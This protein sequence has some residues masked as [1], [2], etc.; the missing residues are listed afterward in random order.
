MAW[1][2]CTSAA[3]IIRAG[4]YANS[5]ITNY[6]TNKTALDNFS[7]E[8]EGFICAY[9]RYNWIS[10]INNITVQFSGAL[11]EACSALIA[12]KIVAYDTTGYPRKKDADTILNLNDEYA[13][14]I[15]RILEQSTNKQVMGAS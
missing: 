7:N 14:R 11:S 1:T 13:M 6:G 10:N 4:A 12:N 9:T 8:I 15:L 5:T 3:A 2:L